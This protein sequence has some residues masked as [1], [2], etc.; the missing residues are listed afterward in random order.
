MKTTMEQ[1]RNFMKCEANRVLAIAYA[2]IEELQDV[3]EKS[4]S[5]G[6]IYNAVHA[7]DE[8]EE[9]IHDFEGDIPDDSW[10]DYAVRDHIQY[11]IERADSVLS[12][13]K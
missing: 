4:T 5:Y 8:L 3:A 10:A 11:F 2:R 12:K 1:L 13:C 6:D 9:R 7:I